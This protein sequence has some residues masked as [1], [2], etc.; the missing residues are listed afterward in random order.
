MPDEMGTS[1]AHLASATA[2]A[3]DEA[4]PAATAPSQL[5]ADTAAVPAEP[6]SHAIAPEPMVSADPV[7]AC[8]SNPEFGA[9][10]PPAG[11]LS[12]SSTE[13]SGSLMAALLGGDDRRPGR[14]GSR[15]AWQPAPIPEERD[16]VP[17]ELGGEPALAFRGAAP[18][19][20]A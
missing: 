2:E 4:S 15:S 8:L 17:A 12:G 5:A 1:S 6:Q 18:A 11:G 16:A 13:L 14:M 3:S 20:T 9:P 10:A 19:C 7:A